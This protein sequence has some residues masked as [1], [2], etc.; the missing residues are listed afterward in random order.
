MCINVELPSLTLPCVYVIATF[1]STPIIISCSTPPR[2]HFCNLDR[3]TCPMSLTDYLVITNRE[4]L[5][6]CYLC[7]ILIVSLFISLYCCVSAGNKIT[8][9]TLHV[10]VTRP[11][12]S[13]HFH[14]PL[15][16]QIN[17]IVVSLRLS[18]M[19]SVTFAVAWSKKSVLLSVQRSLLCQHR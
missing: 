8:T 12:S 13:L 6:V 10:Y 9:T 17:Y 3:V 5:T 16:T 11:C 18:S 7:D 1:K 19:S 2:C 4:H 15:N 14:I